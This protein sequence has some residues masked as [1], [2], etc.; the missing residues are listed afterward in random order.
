LRSEV[1]RRR[2][3]ADHA[4]QPGGIFPHGMDAGEE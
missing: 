3:R 2:E 1:R 4:L